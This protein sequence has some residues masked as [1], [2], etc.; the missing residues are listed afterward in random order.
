[1]GQG[2]ST[3]FSE[4]QRGLPDS[5]WLGKSRAS[6]QIQVFLFLLQSPF[7]ATLTLSGEIIGSSKGI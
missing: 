2:G 5:T 4:R 7:S 3:P 6:F 1:M